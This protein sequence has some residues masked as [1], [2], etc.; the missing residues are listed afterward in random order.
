MAN[1]HMSTG[2]TYYLRMQVNWHNRTV[3]HR[4]TQKNHQ[5]K[6]SYIYTE[7][8]ITFYLC[9]WKKTNTVFAVNIIACTASN[10]L[11]LI[12]CLPNTNP[13]HP[14]SPRASRTCHRPSLSTS[15]RSTPPPPRIRLHLQGSLICQE[16]EE[17]LCITPSLLETN[18]LRPV[19][20]PNTSSFRGIR[21]ASGFSGSWTRSGS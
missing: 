18:A 3:S 1:T 16:I 4:W 2:S 21:R 7:D 8:T 5:L 19:S 15:L 11:F 6:I 9:L 14:S 13:S 20:F 17:D 12:C 10:Y